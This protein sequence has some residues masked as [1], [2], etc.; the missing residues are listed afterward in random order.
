MANWYDMLKEAM[1]K[2]GED[3]T[4]RNCTMD[5]AGLKNYFDDG[6]GYP[7]G[8]PFTAWGKKWVYFP[9]CYDGAEWVGHAPRYPCDIAMD[10][11]GG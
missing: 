6:Y 7:E 9:L 2:D 10:H 5:E 1:E 8:K 4:D 11:Q 3:F